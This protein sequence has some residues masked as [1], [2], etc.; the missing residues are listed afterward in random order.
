LND[1]LKN[2]HLQ[3]VKLFEEYQHPSEGSMRQVRS[4]YSVTGVEKSADKPAQ[5]IGQSTEEILTNLGLNSEEIQQLA[6]AGV[7][8][9]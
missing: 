6:A 1:L 8:N 9:K 3:K 5:L 7:I 2:E 4:H